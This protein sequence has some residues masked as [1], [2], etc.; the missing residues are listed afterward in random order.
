MNGL[1]I[2]LA[3]LSVAF[4]APSGVLLGGHGLGLGGIGLVGPSALGVSVVGPAAHGVSLVGPSTHGAAVVG[5]STLG[6]TV[7][8]PSAGPAAVI[9]A[10]AGHSAIIGASAHGAALVGPSLGLGV[11]LGH[12][13]GLGIGGLAHGVTVAGPPTVPATIT[14]PSGT[15]HAAGL[16]GPTLAHGHARTGTYNPILCL[17]PASSSPLI[18][19][20]L[21][22]YGYLTIYGTCYLEVHIVY[23]LYN[24]LIFWINRVLND[25]VR[26]AANGEGAYIPNHLVLSVDIP[27]PVG[28]QTG[29]SIV[30]PQGFAGPIV[31][32][33]AAIS[34]EPPLVDVEHIS[35]PLPVDVKPIEIV[36]Q[37]LTL[38]DSGRIDLGQVSTN[39][40]S[41]PDVASGSVPEVEYSSSFGVLHAQEL[42]A[43]GRLYAS[44]DLPP[45]ASTL[46]SA[47]TGENSLS[48]FS[49]DVAVAEAL[50]LAGHL[51][52]PDALAESTV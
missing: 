23:T 27:A 35:S 21:V 19:V 38:V 50:I 29:G 37:D 9:G 42:P 52:P 15:V 17:L 49:G 41:L 11:G 5:P 12:G 13:L 8:G 44:T 32:A 30:S 48:L 47:T 46:F 6:A 16:W 34:S 1:I 4:A 18:M 26:N 20:A 10:S 43:S 51:L 25:F 45:A 7:V 36:Q 2:A 24:V 40:L 14:G 33:D 22:D 31:A 39:S 3:T 28:K